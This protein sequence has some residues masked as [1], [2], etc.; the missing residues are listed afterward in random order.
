MRKISLRFFTI[1]S[2]LFF[3]VRRYFYLL[4]GFGQYDGEFYSFNY[5]VKKKSKREKN[6]EKGTSSRRKSFYR[7]IEWMSRRKWNLS[8]LPFLLLFL[9]FRTSMNSMAKANKSVWSQPITSSFFLSFITIFHND[10]NNRE[11][12]INL[13]R[14][15]KC[16]FIKK[17]KENQLVFHWFERVK[18]TIR[19]GRNGSLLVKICRLR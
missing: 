4:V 10:V 6:I 12:S 15:E 5:Q 2:L 1:F 9:L 14:I 17:K 3:K 8:T 19:S 18:F 11:T 7:S 13:V 16:I